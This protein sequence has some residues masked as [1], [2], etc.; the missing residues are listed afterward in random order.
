MLK[1]STVIHL[2]T[3]HLPASCDVWLLRRHKPCMVTTY[4][5]Y[6]LHYELLGPVVVSHIS[7]YKRYWFSEKSY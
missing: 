2:T 5:T 7:L 6:A 3:E 4:E 1:R